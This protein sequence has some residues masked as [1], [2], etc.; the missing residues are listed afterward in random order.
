MNILMLVDDLNIGGTATHILSIS[1]AL[2]EKN[3][4]LLI[5]SHSG[6][7]EEIFEENN[8]K[9]IYLDFYEDLNIISN[10]LLNLIDLYNID[11]LHAH[12]PRS[13][14]ICNRLKEDKNINYIVTLHGLFYKEN[15]LKLCENSNHI[16]CVSEPVKDML[17]SYIDNTSYEKISVIYNGLKPL[18]YFNSNIRNNLNINENFKIITY[19]SRLNNSKGW[20]AEKFLYEFYNIAKKR[21]D[22]YAIILG[23]GPRKRIIDFYANSINDKLKRKAVLVKGNVLNPCDYFIESKCVIGTGRVIIEALNSN[24]GC[25][26]LGSKGFAGLIEPNSYNDMLSTYFGEHKSIEG[27]NYS[28]VESI[29]LILNNNLSLETIITNKLWCNDVF[30]EDLS[31]SKLINIYNK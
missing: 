10:N 3:F 23:D 25:I 27:T 4:N 11:L 2:R 13:I 12:L 18:N 16:I 1:K 29:E 26:A 30:N 31:I 28:F 9:V 24:V 5:V 22:V 14:E 20:L 6:E 15:V 17:L 7:L 8:F 19:C 21:D